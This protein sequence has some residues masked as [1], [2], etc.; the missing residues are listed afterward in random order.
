MEN[1]KNG[2]FRQAIILISTFTASKLVCFVFIASQSEQGIMSSVQ[3]I[4]YNNE[5]SDEDKQSQQ[6]IA[7]SIGSII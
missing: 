2:I 4:T 3:K 7:I 1:E 6:H 5:W